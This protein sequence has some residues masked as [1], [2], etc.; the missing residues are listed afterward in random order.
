MV[1][2]LLGRILSAIFVIWLVLTLTFSLMH[3]IP[4]GPFS[5]EK[6]LPPAVMENINQRYHLNDPLS[7]QYVDYLNNMIHFNFGPTFRYE[8][9][10]V[11]DLFHD[12]LPKTAA[13]GLTATVMALVVGTLMGVIAGLKQNK[14]P[15]YLATILATIGVSVPSFVIA[16]FLQ[17]YVGYKTHLFPPIGW[18]DPIN[19][20]LPA[21]ALSAYPIAQITRLTRSSMLDV[22]NQDYI[23]TARAKGMSEY[24][25]V[26]RHALRNALIPVVTFLGPF[27]AYILTGNFVVE[28][29]FNIPGIGQFFVTSINNRDYPVILGTTVLFATVLV[30]F[31]LLVDIA[32][33]LVDPRIKLTSKKGA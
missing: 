18:G 10:T 27:F 23:R 28:Y 7:K 24:V 1:R 17:F 11:N 29:V 33:T 15:D 12:G 5:S 26:F 32:Y 19:L 16:T 21:I 3:A 6:V 25:V 31:N 8:G 30:L 14:W 9:R 22:L 20:V 4:G 2:Y 13:L